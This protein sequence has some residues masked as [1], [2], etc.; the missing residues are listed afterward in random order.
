MLLAAA[1][2]S[3]APADRRN[4]PRRSNCWT[5]RFESPALPWS[6]RSLKKQARSPTRRANTAST[7]KGARQPKRTAIKGSAAPASRVEAGMAACLIPNAI[8]RRAGEIERTSPRLAAGWL[9]PFPTPAITRQRP[10]NKIPNFIAAMSMAHTA[11][12]KLTTIIPTGHPTLWVKRPPG[13]DMTAETAKKTATK[14]PMVDSRA[15][16][17]ACISPASAAMRKTGSMPM[18]VTLRH[19]N[20]IVRWSAAEFLIGTFPCSRSTLPPTALSQA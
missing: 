19:T 5:I 8:P 18:I 7:T 3:P 20:T 11:T 14:I 4:I 15:A 9:K 1:D 6:T 16:K 12:A 13:I 2:P 17:S 10:R